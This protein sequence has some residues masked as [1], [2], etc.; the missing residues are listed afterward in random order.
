MEI[1]GV[2]NLLGM[3]QSG[4]MEAIGFDL[5]MEMLQECLAEIQGQ[6]IPA[7][8]DT[9]IDL[10]ITAFIPAD[11]IPENEEKMAAY[12]AAAACSGKADLVEL[13]ALWND[14]GS[15]PELA[16]TDGAQAAGTTLRFFAHPAGQTQHRPGD[17]H[18]GARFPATPPW[19]PHSPARTVGVSGRLWKQRQ[20]SGS[21]SG[22]AADRATGGGIEGMAGYDGGTASR[23]GGFP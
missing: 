15:G 7:V 10:P 14:S 1:R 20:G 13:A 9:Q 23:W 19:T 2:G 18:G 17:T 3:E 6:D 16:A 8:E 12:R 21:R 5:Y 4:Q 11:W 22:R